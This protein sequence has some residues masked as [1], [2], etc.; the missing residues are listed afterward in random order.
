MQ[1]EAKHD[2]GIA[3]SERQSDFRGRSETETLARVEFTL[4]NKNGNETVNKARKQE[5]VKNAK[6]R[7]WRRLTESSTFFF[8]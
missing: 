8:R 7:F 5:T 1:A 4:K 6:E 2:T 3:V